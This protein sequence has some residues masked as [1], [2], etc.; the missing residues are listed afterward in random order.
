MTSF[1]TLP[2][3]Q[4]AYEA[5]R[6]YFSAPDAQLSQTTSGGCFYRH[7]EDGRACAVGCLIPDDVFNPD[8]DE[9]GGTVTE[10]VE[11][12]WADTPDSQARAH[13]ERI[14][15]FLGTVQS[16]HDNSSSVE[17][18]LLRLDEYAAARGLVVNA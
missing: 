8:W 7:P 17:T 16:L 1:Y 4:Q 10:I 13:G 12:I 9:V 14:I 15:G 3:R 11:T 6:E 2:T 5:I 18:F